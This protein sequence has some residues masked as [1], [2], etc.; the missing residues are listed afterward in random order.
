[1]EARHASVAKGMRQEDM[2]QPV[3]GV[4]AR[5]KTPSEP[6]LAPLEGEQP[7]SLLV[8]LL[9]DAAGRPQ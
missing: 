8:V 6:S 3:D 5:S 7:L 2:T 1:M 4:E 9:A